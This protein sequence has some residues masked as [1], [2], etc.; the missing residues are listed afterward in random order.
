MRRR[1]LAGVVAA[2]LAGALAVQGCA[3]PDAA[4][5][6]APAQ[7]PCGPEVD[8]ATAR[9]VD[10]YAAMLGHLVRQRD[11]GVAGAEVLYLVDHAVPEFHPSGVPEWEKQTPA[12]ASTST[13]EFTPAVRRCLEAARFDGLPPVRLVED[14]D[15]PAIRS[16]PVAAKGW[17]SGQEQPRRYLD[18]RL[19]YLGGVPDRGDRL[20]LAASS[21]DATYDLAG[22]LFVLRRRAGAWRVTEQARTWVS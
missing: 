20:A 7:H 8:Q 22:G 18:G 12:P 16:E 13:A 11:H 17:P 10:V 9:V 3:D 15:D 21:S 1:R 5:V 19:F 4:P 2:L 14:Y 6:A